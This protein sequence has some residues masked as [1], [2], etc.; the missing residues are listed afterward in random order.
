MMKLREL[1]NGLDILE[2]NAGLDSD[3]REVRY[4][5]RLVESGD[6]FIA[7][8]GAETDGH[9]YIPMAR[10]KGA[11]CVLCERAPED[12]APFVRVA[13]SRRALAV[14]GGNRFDHP[15]REMTMI[16][17]TGTSGKT[18][19]TYLI[20]SILEQKAGAKVGLIGTIQ[21]M[22]GDRVLHTERTTPES[23]ELQKLFAQMAD[24][25][26]THCVMEVSSH[27][28]VLHRADEI[29]F[30]TGI[31]TN[32]TEDHLDFHK[33]MDAYCEAKAMLFTRCRHGVVNTD[34]A[35]AQKI[36]AHATCSLLRYAEKDS[37]AELRAEDIELA[38]DHVAFTAKTAHEQAQVRLAIPGGFTVYNALA[39]IGAGLTLG[40]PLSKIA[41]ALKTA[42]GVK[43]RVEVV[44]TPGKPYT[45]LID[46]SHTPDSLE[47]VLKTVRGFCKGR[48]IAVFGCGGD[49]DP[50]KRPIMGRIGAELADLC[51]VTSDNPRT[52]DPMAIIDAIVSGMQE[53]KNPY[54]VIEN[55]V[56]AIG[57]AMA[58]AQKDD[59]IVLCGKG[60]ETYQEIGHEKRHLDEREVV[61]DFLG[62]EV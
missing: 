40:I 14:V 24:A 19:S 10:E 44:P 8:T 50:F 57:W 62:R 55:R 12:G 36:M 31:F 43:G 33:T 45:V 23:F 42:S 22:I 37:E 29:S 49:R 26:C 25:G 61:A 32:L 35:Y 38:A 30:E 3:I 15:A 13:D 18:T 7:V 59:V 16:G 11:A 48:V 28:L 4:D 5:S 6:L 34:D 56:E 1:L 53:S 47:N 39:V 2:T 20:K 52:E 54:V 21:N 51:V 27:A 17:I 41:D 9:K 46:Y 58:H 60:H